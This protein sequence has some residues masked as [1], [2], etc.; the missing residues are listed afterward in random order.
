MRRGNRFQMTEATTRTPGS[1]L[2]DQQM[3]YFTCGACR[4]MIYPAIDD[5][6]AAY[7]TSQGDIQYDA[8]TYACTILNFCQCSC[9]RVIIDD[10]GDVETF[11]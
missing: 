9:I 1:I 4:T 8:L 10:T 7:A 5:H 2:L 6:T 11:S 3:P